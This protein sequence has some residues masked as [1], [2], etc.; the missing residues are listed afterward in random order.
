MNEKVLKTLEY[1]KIIEL[2]VSKS[3]SNMGKELSSELLPTTDLDEIIKNQKETTEATHIIL[4]KGSLPLGGIKDI[5]RSLK[6]VAISGVLSI[7]ELLHIGDF[8][9]VC[10]KTSNYIKNENRNENK[11]EEFELVENYFDRI[12]TI[13]SLEKEIN[14][15]IANENEINDEATKELYD[16]RRS[17]KSSNSKIKEQLNNIIHSASYKNMIQDAVITI[18]N[19]RFCVPIKQEYR[20]S[21]PGMVHDQS[22]TGATCF[23]EPM[24]VV[25]LNNKIKELVAKEKTEIDKIL[26]MLSEMVNEYSEQLQNNTEILTYLDFVFAKGELSISMNATEPVFNTKGYIN[27]IKARHPILTGTVIPIDI[28]IGGDFNTL[29]IT[30]PNTGGKT[31]ALKTLGL[32]TLMGQ[33]G[34]HIAAFDHSELAVFDEVF[35]DIGDEQSIE[36]SLSTFSSHMTNIVK[37]LSEV[38][39]N[40]LVLLDELGAGTDPTEG[41][42]LGISIL[43]HLHKMQIR[44]AVTTHYSELKVYALSTDGVENASCEFDVETL[45]PTYKLL[46]GI[47]GKSNAFAISRR[48]GLDDTIIND[49]KEFI[50]HENIRFEDVITDLEISKKSVALEQRRAEEYRQEAEKLKKEFE[51]QK[52]KLNN[53]RDK[54]LLDAKDEARRLMHQ[55]KEEADLLIRELQKQARENAL[56]KEMDETRNKIKNKLS[57]LEDDLSNISKPKKD[58]RQIDKKL[59]KGDTVFVH[60]LNQSGVVEKDEEAN[61]DVMVQVGIMK[62]K[63]HKSNLSLEKV[64]FVQKSTA[65]FSTAVKKNKSL[66]IMNELDLRGNTIEEGLEKTDKYLDDAYLSGLLQVTIIHGK[67]TGALRSA[68]SNHLRNHPVVKSYRLGV[69]GEGET[70]VTVVEL[71]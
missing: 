71:K 48:L 23:I 13:S 57:G 64:K 9:Y 49:A 39:Y 18:R 1:N 12:E 51:L 27:I 69:F 37:I 34:L 35:A 61:G 44:V 33:S 66:T 43:E 4:K 3:I 62:T 63:I 52:Q 40:S 5:R 28:Y 21:F 26:R 54:I 59:K 30:G 16:I 36:Q 14:R 67:G 47:P 38:N 46:I 60:T 22:S 6:R 20:N 55:T 17:I 15:C 31:V 7:E 32:F 11:T 8:L 58:I 65:R 50:S 29:L 2:L 42:A 45:R 24:S 56:P 10:K 53:Q 41:A 68:I 19:D 25:T 70:G